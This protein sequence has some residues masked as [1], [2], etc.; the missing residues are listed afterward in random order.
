MSYFVTGGTGFIGRHLIEQLCQRGE[1]IYVLIRKPSQPK[2]EKLQD[3]TGAKSGQLVAIEGDL[4]QPML[5]VGKQDLALLAKAGIKHFYHLAAIYDLK[6]DAESQQVANIQGT[7]HALSLA[8]EIQAGCFNHVSSIA[9]GGLYKGVFREDMFEQATETE[10]PYFRTKHLSEGLVRQQCQI[11][12]RIYRPGFVVGH[13]KTGE[14]DKVDGP[15]YFFKMLQKA[16]HTF[17]P[18]MPLIG[19]EG[20]K[21]NIVPVDFVASAID[22]IS[23][24]PDRN[25]GCFHLT[26]TESH[27]VGE[28]LNIFAN[29]GHAPHFAMRID[30]RLFDF[31]PSSIRDMLR[32]LAPV[33]RVLN[34]IMDDLGIPMDSLQFINW[35]T[36]YDNREAERALSDSDI[37]VPPLADYA[38]ALWDFWER[39]LDPDLHKD[40]SLKGNVENKVIMITGASSGIGQATALKLAAAGAQVVLVARDQDKLEL[41][42]EKIVRSGGRAFSYSCDVSDLESCD[43]LVQQ[44]LN[45]HGHVDV[46]INN[47]GR[48]IRRSIEHTLDRFHDF[49]V[50]PVKALELATSHIT[51]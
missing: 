9:A 47:A 10:H 39:N 33:K 49:E 46:L 29:A 15:Y 26:D 17:P 34:A 38:P 48:S 6:A 50:R 25:G 2:L 32:N 20:G 4:A 18:W 28:V 22:H 43:N 51:Y 27:R 30:S 13:S 11:P 37:H 35:P 1:T 19:L 8:E 23:H 21:L 40:S 36:R 14:M 41:T 42:R 7:E 16:R 31:I 3:K 45:D 5:G 44:V 12:Y 24:K